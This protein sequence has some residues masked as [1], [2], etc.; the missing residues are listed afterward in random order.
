[1]SGNEF[2]FFQ[3][4]NGIE[5]GSA[6]EPGFNKKLSQYG[7]YAEG[8]ENA[9]G[10]KDEIANPMPRDVD[11][12]RV[13]NPFQ[14]GSTLKRVRDDKMVRMSMGDISILERDVSDRKTAEADQDVYMPQ[15]GWRS[16]GG[17]YD[18]SDSPSY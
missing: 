5:G 3:I 8:T 10:F 15:E 17:K 11:G 14:E 1:M 13:E 2:N 9:Y 4:T 18:L 16:F 6:N 12:G 7:A